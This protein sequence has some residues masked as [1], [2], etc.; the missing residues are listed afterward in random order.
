[1]YVISLYSNRYEKM[2]ETELVDRIEASRAFAYL[3]S[4]SGLETCHEGD[5]KISKRLA[6]ICFTRTWNTLD[7]T[8]RFHSIGNVFDDCARRRL[9][10]ATHFRRTIFKAIATAD[11]L[12]VR[13][14]ARLAFLNF[15]RAEN[16]IALR[17][18]SYN[19]PVGQP[20]PPI[21]ASQRRLNL[22][23]RHRVGFW[24]MS[25]PRSSRDQPQ[26]SR[27]GSCSPCK[28]DPRVQFR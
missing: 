26:V 15:S 13:T 1:M 9:L 6:P 2:C 21:A 12:I 7:K 11:W 17:N 5:V 20:N 28:K 14:I 3:T 8:L 10:Y 25:R 18:Y 23:D 22:I 4:R 24:H 27:Q 19:F 16:S